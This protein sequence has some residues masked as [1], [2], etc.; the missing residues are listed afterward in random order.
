MHRISRLSFFVYHL[1]RKP[2][3]PFHAP[4]AEDDEGNAEQLT[5]IEGQRVLEVHLI[6]LQKLHKEAESEDIGEAEAEVETR[7]YPTLYIFVFVFL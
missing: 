7:P 2:F 5:H 6:D 4:H 1:G 3:G